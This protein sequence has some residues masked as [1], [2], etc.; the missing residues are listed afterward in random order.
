M[1]YFGATLFQVSVID[2]FLAFLT[3]A[4]SWA[5]V[6]PLGPSSFAPFTIAASAAAAEAPLPTAVPSAAFGSSFLGISCVSVLSQTEQMRSFVPVLDVVAGV[7]I[8]QS[9]QV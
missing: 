5:N 6:V 7:T 3:F 1:I 8:F 9:D 4:D 2:V